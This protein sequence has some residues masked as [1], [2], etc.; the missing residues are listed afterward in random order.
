MEFY[1]NSNSM[2]FDFFQKK[3]Q[4][5]TGIPVESDWNC[6]SMEFHGIPWN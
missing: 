3:F 5:G 6:D 2:E 4:D 1:W